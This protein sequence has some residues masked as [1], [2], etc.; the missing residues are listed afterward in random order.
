MRRNIGMHGG[1]T[2][3]DDPDCGLLFPSLVVL[4]SDD[5]LPMGGLWLPIPASLRGVALL[6]AMLANVLGGAEFDWWWSMEVGMA[7]GAS[8]T[9]AGMAATAVLIAV[10][11][12][13]MSCLC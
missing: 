5:S 3:L 10:L 13:W 8:A 11:S 2:H 12:C 6:G 4:L 7:G 1:E 9:V